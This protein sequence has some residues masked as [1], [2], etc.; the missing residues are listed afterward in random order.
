M[1]TK[2]ED[3]ENTQGVVYPYKHVKVHPYRAGMAPAMWHYANEYSWDP[4]GVPDKEK[5]PNAEQESNSRKMEGEFVGR[6]KVIRKEGEEKIEGDGLTP[7]VRLKKD[8][9]V[10]AKLGVPGVGENTSVEVDVMLDSG[11][12]VNAIS[13]ALVT[14]LQAETPGVS[15]TRKLEGQAWVVT[16]TGEEREVTTQTCP[17]HLIVE[18]PAKPVRFTIPFMVIPGKE[19]LVIVGRTTMAEDWGFNLKEQFLELVKRRG[20][21]NDDISPTLSMTQPCVE[22]PVGEFQKEGRGQEGTEEMDDAV[23][24]MVT[25]ESMDA[26]AGD[27]GRIGKEKPQAD[28][29]QLESTDQAARTK[30]RCDRAKE[31]ESTDRIGSTNDTVRDGAEKTE[32]AERITQQQEGVGNSAEM[33]SQGVIRAYGAQPGDPGGNRRRRNPMDLHYE[34]ARQRGWHAANEPGATTVVQGRGRGGK[35]R[36]KRRSRAN[37]VEGRC[38][39]RGARGVSIPGRG[40]STAGAAGETRDVNCRSHATFIAG[41]SVT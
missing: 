14:K 9:C 36:D 40:D 34:S 4:A 32:S 37:Q 29:G 22:T 2:Q 30:E 5:I 15:F 6:M 13:E 35:I 24:R 10:R 7:R 31:A 33:A 12:G 28:T 38:T 1:G 20:S 3:G 27:S 41:A 21:S 25:Q 23:G 16:A 18:S 26:S 8:E 19:D 17:M 11:S 39:I